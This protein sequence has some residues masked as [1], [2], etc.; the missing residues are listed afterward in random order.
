MHARGGDMANTE[1]NTWVSRVLG[2]SAAAPLTP[3]PTPGELLVQFRDAKE[4]VDAGIARLQAA[5][6]DTGDE[7]LV[8]VA[9]YGLYGMGGGQGGR[10][11]TTLMDLRAAPQNK[12]EATAKAAR[13][14]AAAYKAAVLGHPLAELLDANPFGVDVG[15]Q[16]RLAPVLET[17]MHVA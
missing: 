15:L 11:V 12:H 5:L 10:L 16:A 1:Q 2:V 8:R 6:R 4:A 17:I 9:E 3:S 7:D 13:Q 14:A